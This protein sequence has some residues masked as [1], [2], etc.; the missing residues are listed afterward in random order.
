MMATQNSSVLNDIVGAFVS[1]GRTILAVFI[2]VIGLFLGAI[3]LAAVAVSWLF[4]WLAFKLRLSKEP[5]R[6]KFQRVQAKLAAK[7]IQYKLRKSGVMP[8]GGAGVDLA[9]LLGQFQA[10]QQP[11]ASAGPGPGN[12]F[13]SVQSEPKKR[14]K[15]AGTQTVVEPKG[16]DADDPPEVLPEEAD[17]FHGSIEEYVRRKRN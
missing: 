14:K 5:P 2:A 12:P 8:P 7:F 16:A 13:G 17:E 11:G 15:K 6:V 3:L 4:F 9:D 10:G 1:V